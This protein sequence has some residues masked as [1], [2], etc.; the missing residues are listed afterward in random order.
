MQQALLDLRI[1]QQQLILQRT[2]VQKVRQNRDLVAKSYDAG[3][4]MMARLN[5]AQRD[6]TR[7]EAQLA[8]AR[9]EL[10]RAWHSLQIA[11]A[12]KLAAFEEESENENR[13]A[14]PV[15][16]RANS[17]SGAEDAP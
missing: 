17:V 15:I 13:V 2:T 14:E 1:A 10:Q 5:Q 6:L 11:T 8:L 16:R 12:Q 4:E 3:K 7:A 9:V